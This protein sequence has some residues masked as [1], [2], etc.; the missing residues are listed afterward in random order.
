MLA[1]RLHC[2]SSWPNAQLLPVALSSCPLPASWMVF[3]AQRTPRAHMSSGASSPPRGDQPPSGGDADPALAAA[4][5]K[6]RVNLDVPL[7]RKW[8][9]QIQAQD[10]HLAAVYVLRRVGHCA[11][12]VV[13]VVCQLRL[14]YGG[15]TQWCHTGYL[16]ACASRK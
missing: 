10:A 14:L 2:L 12:C 1:R 3:P 9:Y 15:P 7:L 13:R 6:V 8:D 11:F 4:A 16:A 5:A